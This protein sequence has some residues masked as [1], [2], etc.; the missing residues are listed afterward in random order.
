MANQA[1]PS[2]EADSGDELRRVDFDSAVEFAI[3][4]ADTRQDGRRRPGSQTGVADVGYGLATAAGD[5][6]SA[7]S[8]ATDSGRWAPLQSFGRSRC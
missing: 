4:A 1:D 7:V 5:L 3:I 2:S 6:D 8:S